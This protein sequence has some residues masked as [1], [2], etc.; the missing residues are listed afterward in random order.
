M[1][2]KKKLHDFFKLI[3]LLFFMTYKLSSHDFFIEPWFNSNDWDFY[4]IQKLVNHLHSPF[5]SND[6]DFYEY[7]F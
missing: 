7:L 2:Y 5:N 1:F 4:D 6:W 3:I